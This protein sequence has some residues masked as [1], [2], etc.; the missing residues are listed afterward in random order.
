MSNNF[1]R[2]DRA[3]HLHL[4]YSSTRLLLKLIPL[5][6]A[7]FVIPRPLKNALASILLD[8]A[9]ARLYPNI[10]ETIFQFV[11]VNSMKSVLYVE[12]K[13]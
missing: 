12:M 2:S 13:V 4:L 11:K 10:H 3:I 7:D 6:K 9:L 8:S 1:D 5:N